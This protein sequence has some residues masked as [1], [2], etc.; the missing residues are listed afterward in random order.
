VDGYLSITD[1]KSDVIIRGGEN[2]SAVEIEEA[3]L[4]MTGVCEVSSTLDSAN[5]PPPCCA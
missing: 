3:L 5:T 4:G 2:I 1:R